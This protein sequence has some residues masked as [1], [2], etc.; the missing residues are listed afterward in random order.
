M[1]NTVL[2]DGGFGYIQALT[3]FNDT[4]VI[5]PNLVGNYQ[6]SIDEGFLGNGKDLSIKVDGLG[7]WNYGDTADLQSIGGGTRKQSGDKIF[8]LEFLGSL[9]LAIS[10]CFSS[11]TRDIKVNVVTGLPGA[12][13]IQ[14]KNPDKVY[15]KR[16]KNFIQGDYRIQRLGFNQNIQN[17]YFLKSL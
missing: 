9:L 10:E 7:Q 5:F 12:E 6:P 13:Y 15:Q 2:Y 16:F 14:Y 1:I 17:L 3:S 4:N 8:S 11:S